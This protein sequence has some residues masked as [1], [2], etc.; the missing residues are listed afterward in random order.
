MLRLYLLRHAKS[1]WPEGVSDHDRPLAPRGREAAPR[2]GIFMRQEGYL[3]NRIIVSTALRTQ[4]TFAL[5]NEKLSGPEPVFTN[6]VYGARAEELLQLVRQVSAANSALLLVGHNPGMEDLTHWLLDEKASNPAAMQ[7]LA[8][9]YPTAA[10]AIFQF[11][12]EDWANISK[13]SG[14]LRQFITPRIL[15][16]VDED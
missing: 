6:A 9:G 11:K 14:N 12:T 2:M 7:A 15:G 8:L 16:G 13:S 10:L 3:P 1:A 5:L 4:Q